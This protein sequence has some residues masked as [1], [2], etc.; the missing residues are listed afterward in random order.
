MNGSRP[1][2]LSIN[3]N[4]QI[5]GLSKVWDN[6]IVKGVADGWQISGISS[7]LSG[8]H[9]NFTYS[10]T[11]APY[12]DMTGGG[13]GGSR[14]TLVCNPTIPRKDRTL[15]RQF[16]T[17]CIQ[18]AGP[19]SSA[20]TSRCSRTSRWRAGATC[21]C[22]SRCTTRSTRCSQARLARVRRSTTR[23]ERC[24]RIPRSARSQRRAPGLSASSSSDCGSRSRQTQ[25]RPGPAARASCSFL[26]HPP[27]DTLARFA[28]RCRGV[29][30]HQ[31]IQP[32]CAR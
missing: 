15:L 6:A 10:F 22:E 27:S 2:V 32:Y 25:G 23:R 18:P 9:A 31:P 24:R 30:Y 19:T 3:Y 20:T 1:H 11:G 17:D 26:V 13:I 12:S 7:F 8:T 4:Y 5:P 16:N 29:G 21:R 28:L 14:V